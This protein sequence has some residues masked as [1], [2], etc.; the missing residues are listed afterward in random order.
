M[1]HSEEDAVCNVGYHV[2]STLQ[3]VAL[4]VSIFRLA[5]YPTGKLCPQIDTYIA[6][7]QR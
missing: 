3:A 6:T 2:D 1:V 4:L 5:N 7:N